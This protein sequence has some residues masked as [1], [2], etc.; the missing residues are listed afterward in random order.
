MNS[1]HQLLII[2]TRR[3]GLYQQLFAAAFE[4][5]TSIREDLDTEPRGIL[6]GQI[7]AVQPL[8]PGGEL[9]PFT[10]K[11]Q[12]FFQVLV[13]EAIDGCDRVADIVVGAVLGLVPHDL[14][15]YAIVGRLDGRGG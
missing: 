10:S 8:V 13:A 2:H 4:H 15:H 1:L 6:L 9:Q 3:L 5:R 7:L 14:V 11:L 12:A